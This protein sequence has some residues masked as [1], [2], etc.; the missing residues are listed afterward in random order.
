[1]PVTISNP[2]DLLVQL[3]GELLFVERR[4]AGGVLRDLIDAVTDQELADGL[5]AH[6]E[7]TKAHVERCETAFRALEVAPTANQSNAFESAVKEHDELSSSFV[8]TALADV[9]H[10]QAALQTE[11]ME[12]A[13][14]SAVLGFGDAAG[15]GDALAPL[16]ES[17]AD[18]NEAREILERELRRLGNA[19]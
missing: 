6:L 17:L 5:R 15:F 14:Y 18:E 1:V 11:H 3:L 12:I 19:R 10:A 8:S 2:R 4:L 16:R 9:F 13:L 7:Q